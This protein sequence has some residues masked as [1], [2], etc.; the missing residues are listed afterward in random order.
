MVQVY[1]RNWLPITMHQV[2]AIR[3]T[4]L[5]DSRAYQQQQHQWQKLTIL[6]LC[7]W[8]RKRRPPQHE[9]TAP[10]AWQ[11][12]P[13]TYCT[14]LLGCSRRYKIRCQFRK[15]PY[16]LSTFISQ[17]THQETIWICLGMNVQNCVITLAI[18]DLNALP[19]SGQLLVITPSMSVELAGHVR[20]VSNDLSAAF[21]LCMHMHLKHESKSHR[22]GR[23]HHILIGLNYRWD[24]LAIG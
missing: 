1:R 10:L 4:I 9:P 21:S 20:T 3:N 7:P 8:P 14:N 2:T 12:T 23:Q 15:S 13:R 17:F 6:P 24:L 18:Y 22:K 16:L 11:L 19:W 5:V